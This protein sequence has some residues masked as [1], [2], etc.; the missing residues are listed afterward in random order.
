ME[1]LCLARYEFPGRQKTIS[2]KRGFTNVDRKGYQRL[3]AE[4]RVSKYVLASRS[5]WCSMLTRLLS[6]GAV[7]FPTRLIWGNL[8][9]QLHT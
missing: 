6:D 1:A 4:K 9:A 2:L 3:K 8:R 5:R 7:H